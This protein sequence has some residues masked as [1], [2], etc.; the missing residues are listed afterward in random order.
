MVA[1]VYLPQLF[2]E[3]TGLESGPSWQEI[4]AMWKLTLVIYIYI[5]DIYH[6]ESFP[7]HFD[8][9]SPGITDSIS[10]NA[11]VSTMGLR[12]DPLLQPPMCF[13]G[14]KSKEAKWTPAHFLALFPFFQHC[15]PI[16]GGVPSPSGEKTGVGHNRHHGLSGFTDLGHPP[17][18]QA[19]AR[20]KRRHCHK[21]AE[22][23]AA[24]KRLGSI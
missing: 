22:E 5:Y 2:A 4:R 3:R 16:F 24:S 17:A 1:P 21:L 18:S 10:L 7:C 15:C 23:A 20:V 14:P 9:N 12:Q 6:S 11:Y 13:L 8:W 19:W